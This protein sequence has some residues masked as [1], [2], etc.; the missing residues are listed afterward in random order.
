LGE[1]TEQRPEADLELVRVSIR[2]DGAFGVL[3]ALQVPPGQDGIPLALTCER[4]YPLPDTAHGQF[5]K[6]P[7]GRHRCTRD[8]YYK[9]RHETY[10]VH[11]AGH[12]RLL[13]H[14]GNAE[15]DAEGCVLVGRRFGLLRGKPAILESAQGFADFMA[16]AGRRQLFTLLVRHAA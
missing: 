10:E 7:A 4:T 12:A 16:W 9:G 13:F 15:T 5:I 11:V 14:K 1:T 2:E 3:Q 6:I 8:Y